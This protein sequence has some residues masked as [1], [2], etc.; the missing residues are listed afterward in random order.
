MKAKSEMTKLLLNTAKSTE[1]K[2]TKAEQYQPKI[3]NLAE[4]KSETILQKETVIIASPPD[5]DK[6]EDYF[7]NN[8]D[9]GVGDLNIKI[10]ITL[11][12]E[13][14]LLSVHSGIPMAK[15]ISNILSDFLKK[16]KKDINKMMKR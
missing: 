15:I 13:Y 8:T 11:H 7:N 16:N 4:V 6:F 1:Q 10:P 2:E 3:D 5:A 9:Y 14:K 12:K